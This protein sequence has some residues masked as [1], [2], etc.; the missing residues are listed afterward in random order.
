MPGARRAKKGQTEVGKG[1]EAPAGDV[2]DKKSGPDGFDGV[3]NTN[4]GDAGK[5]PGGRWSRAYYE[6]G[7]KIIGKVNVRDA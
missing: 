1:S 5:E 3:K 4:A 6:S 2:W 7:P